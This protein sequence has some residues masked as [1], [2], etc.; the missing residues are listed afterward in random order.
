MSSDTAYV[1]LRV[2]SNMLREVDARAKRE[3]STR[4]RFILMALREKLE[5]AP[6]IPAPPKTDARVNP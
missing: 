5:A 1:G 2:P 6:G 3:F 4:T